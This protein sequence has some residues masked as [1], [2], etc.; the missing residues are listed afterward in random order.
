MPMSNVAHSGEQ[1]VEQTAPGDVMFIPV[2]ANLHLEVE[3]QLE[4]KQK[5]MH[6]TVFEFC[7]NEVRQKLQM[8]GGQAMP[9]QH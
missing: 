1:R 4:E 8:E 6:V 3:R 5:S 9:R 7:V 2:R